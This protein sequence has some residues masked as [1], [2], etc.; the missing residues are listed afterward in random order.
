M[1]LSFAYSHNRRTSSDIFSTIKEGKILTS[2]P[3]SNIILSLPKL[4]RERINLF[5]NLITPTSL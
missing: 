4:Y 2:V 3:E 1:Q 5:P